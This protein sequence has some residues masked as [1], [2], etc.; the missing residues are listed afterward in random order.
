MPIERS[1]SNWGFLQSTL[2]PLTFTNLH[3]HERPYNRVR[4][5]ELYASCGPIL[6][7]HIM[8]A[9][10]LL[11]ETALCS[12]VLIRALLPPCMAAF[13]LSVI[14]NGITNASRKCRKCTHYSSSLGPTC[15]NSVQG[16][17]RTLPS[18]HRSWGR[19]VLEMAMSL[20]LSAAVHLHSRSASLFQGV[21]LP[22]PL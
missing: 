22:R 10:L 16:P 21:K 12:D 17:G 7:L 19:L 15:Y 11:F 5:P 20:F 8:I 9:M 6:S 14:T 3:T 4:L 2:T 18:G 1:C 13:A